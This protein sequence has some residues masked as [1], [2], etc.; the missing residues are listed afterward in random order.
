MSEE[1]VEIM[2][3]ALEAFN[4]RDG[5]A[6]GALLADDAEIV[7]VRAAVEGTTYRG[8]DAAAQ[9]CAAVDESWEDLSW[10]VEEIRDGDGWIIA[11]GHIRGHGRG[12]GAA[13]DAKGAWVA[14]FG[15]ELITGFHTYANRAEA[16]EAVGLSE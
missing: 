9:Y 3:A 4:Q 14:H 7:P 10:E 8:P 5:E 15:G 11:L 16:L 13:F 6:F 1:N 12:S 2:R